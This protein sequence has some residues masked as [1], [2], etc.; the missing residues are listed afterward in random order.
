[1]VSIIDGDGVPRLVAKLATDTEGARRLANEVSAIEQIASLL[2]AP[3]SAPVVVAQATGLA[4]FEFVPWLPRRDATE[5]PAE[6]AFALGRFYLACDSKNGCGAVHGDF[7]PW[8]ILQTTEG[9]TL[10]DWEAASL[11]GRPF[12]DLCHYFV[13]SHVLLGRP[14]QDAIVDGFR[15]GTGEIG[16][17]VRAYADG[18]KVRMDL[19]ASSLHAYLVT[20]SQS[21][22]PEDRDRGARARDRLRRRL[23][24]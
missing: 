1:V 7:A 4:V 3:L 22:L 20:S 13:Q 12:E 5:L 8:N 24:R 23:E 11:H 19:A 17:I 10:L 21:L 16:G 9:W 18:A 14:S 2:G 6:V 15:H